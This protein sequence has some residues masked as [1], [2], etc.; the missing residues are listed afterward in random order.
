[1]FDLAT[2]SQPNA[3][4]FLREELAEMLAESGLP[5]VEEADAAL[6]CIADVQA[7]AD[8]LVRSQDANAAQF[9]HQAQQ[10]TQAAAVLR[11]FVERT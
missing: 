10:L 5:T 2:I 6:R 7:V 8:S 9:H 11:R 3:H 1:M 4:Q